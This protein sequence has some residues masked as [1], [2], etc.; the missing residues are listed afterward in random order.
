MQALALHSS[1]FS[2]PALLSFL[3]LVSPQPGMLLPGI[4][5]NLPSHFALWN[6]V[7]PFEGPTLQT[8][9]R[10]MDTRL[11]VANFPPALF[12]YRLGLLIWVLI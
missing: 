7:P 12:R 8:L 5:R 10:V 3:V 11:E 2:K 4:G 6:L 1:L 9:L